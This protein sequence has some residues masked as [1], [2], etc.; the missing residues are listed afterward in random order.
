MIDHNVVVKDKKGNIVGEGNIDL[1]ENLAE[2]IEAI[3]EAKVFACFK[4][5]FLSNFSASLRPQAPTL[6]KQ[7]KTKEVYDKLKEAQKQT[8][9]TDEMIIDI[10]GYDPALVPVE[11][12]SE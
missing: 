12:E 6:R 3:G 4:T 5:T 11:P 2:A 8:K 1:P 10:S 9:M 7:T